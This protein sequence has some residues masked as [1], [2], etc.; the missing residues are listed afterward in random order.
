M[1]LQLHCIITMPCQVTCIHAS[2]NLHWQANEKKKGKTVCINHKRQVN[3]NEINWNIFGFQVVIL[4]G[5]STV[6]STSLWPEHV[7][8][9]IVHGWE[10]NVIRCSH[11]LATELWRMY[12]DISSCQVILFT[13]V[14]PGNIFA[15]CHIGIHVT[16]IQC[17]LYLIW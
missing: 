15:C 3:K 8:A 9:S 1:Y 2:S 13:T 7:T 6:S 11:N 5:K 14:C 4:W 16:V 10:E 12:Q 17:C